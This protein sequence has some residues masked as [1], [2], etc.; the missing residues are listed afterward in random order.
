MTDIRNGGE[1]AGREPGTGRFAAGNPGRP[2][3]T[4]LKATLTAEA[5]LDGE[6]QA[7]TRKAIEAALDGGIMALRLCLERI[8]PARRL[9]IVR[10]DLPRLTS[11]ADAPAAVAAITEA[12]SAGE[13]APDEAAELTRLVEGFVKVVEISDMERRLRALEEASDR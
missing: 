7:L 6:A 2:R 13:I 5:L 10:V 9:R 11:V 3:G 1:I 8:L 4:R 12:V